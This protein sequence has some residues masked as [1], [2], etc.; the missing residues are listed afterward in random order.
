MV[1]P[2]PCSGLLV[3][4]TT[5]VIGHFIYARKMGSLMAV[6]LQFGIVRRNHQVVVS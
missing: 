2:V 6:K 3:S 1:L 5:M 4:I